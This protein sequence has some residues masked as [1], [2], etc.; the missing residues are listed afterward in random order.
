MIGSK[1][2]RNLTIK[3]FSGTTPAH[4]KQKVYNHLALNKIKATQFQSIHFKERVSRCAII[5]P[6]HSVRNWLI[7]NENLRIILTELIKLFR[8]NQTP[9]KWFLGGTPPSNRVLN[10][11][12]RNVR[13][14]I[15]GNAQYLTSFHIINMIR[16]LRNIYL[17]STDLN[18]LLITRLQTIERDKSLI[19]QFLTTCLSSFYR[20]KK[21]KQ[22]FL[23]PEELPSYFL[24]RYFQK[25]KWL[26]SRMNKKKMDLLEFTCFKEKRDKAWEVLKQ[27]FTMKLTHFSPIEVNIM[28]QK[29][30]QAV[31]GKLK[32]QSSN[33]LTIAI[34]HPLFQK[35]RIDYNTP[36]YSDFLSYFQK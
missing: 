31:F 20:K 15:F 19:E 13:N 24:E 32:T 5:Y 27:E 25:I 2:I 16:Q 28:M 14:D 12:F 6:Y 18:H 11:L 17:S 30:C 21:R 34:Y 7:R 36:T 23:A 33:H 22:K 1:Y 8:T 3:D 4:I 26:S 35:M 10:H 29:A 9:L